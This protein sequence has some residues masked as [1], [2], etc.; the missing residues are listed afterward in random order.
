MEITDK[1][2]QHYR[3]TRIKK[4]V[5]ELLTLDSG[6]KTKLDAAI[7]AKKKGVKDALPKSK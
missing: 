5:E 7:D 1:V 2:R 4:D 6:T 3:L